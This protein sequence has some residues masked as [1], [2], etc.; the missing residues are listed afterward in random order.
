[1]TK[2]TERNYS[3]DQ[4]MLNVAS[5]LVSDFRRDSNDP[6]FAA[7]FLSKVEIKD[8]IGARESIPATLESDDPWTF[9]AK[10]QI[11]SVFKRYRFQVDTYSD[12]EL[13]DK[14]VKSF[15]ETQDRL[16]HVDLERQSQ[17]VNAVLDRAARYI[18]N[19]L[20]EYDD[21]E[22]RDLCR[23][24]R[25]ASVGIPARKAC[26]A[27]RWEV[28]VSGSHE[29][30]SW[31]D[32]EMSQIE[33]VKTY[34]QTQIDSDPERRSIYQEVDSLTLVLV[35]KTFKSLRSIMPNTTIGSYMSYGLGE[36]MRIRLKRKGYDIRTLQMRHRYLAQLAS[37][38]N[39][40][41]TADLSSASDSISVAL[42]D[43]LF[44]RDWCEILHR[45]RVGR[46]NLPDSTC[47]ES[48]TFC[49]MGV[50][51]TFPLQT[52]VFLALLKAIESCLFDRR[53]RRTI[54]VY[55]DDMIYHKRL[56]KA[57]VHV[58][59]QI[60]FVI[61]L[62]KTYHDSGFRESCG[63]DYFHGV[64]VRPFQPQNGPA[65]VGKKAYEAI[66]YKYINGLLMRWSEYEIVGT[67]RYLTSEL[68]T[69]VGKCKLVPGD[70]P[71]DAGIKCPTLTHW[72]FLSVVKCVKPKHIGH[73][74]YRFPYL[75]FAS[76]I[77]KEVRHEPYVW[78]ALRC[79]RNHSALQLVHFSYR[80]PAECPRRNSIDE[81]TGVDSVHVPLLITKEDRPIKT[82]RSKLTG[83]R[84]RRT[85]TFV[86]I[87][88]R[89]RY[90]RQSGT[91]C[92]EDRR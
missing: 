82:F 37:Q 85:S 47:I 88:Q 3:V 75:R 42:V 33:S 87:G 30:I 84:L 13:L 79:R 8:V 62:D 31:F 59:T 70:F 39:L 1:M 28:P 24:G 61:N 60:G 68:E 25:R 11:Q 54:S 91:S 36:M 23:F 16:A 72:N 21:A 83:R 63:G 38:N 71:D 44:P 45:S 49:T 19:C 26:E 53:D 12:Q 5:T 9:K 81:L 73:G 35:P 69:L 48:L 76:E 34:W 40:Y 51:Y 90:M 32:S 20:G 56:H 22:H 27:A 4:L 66:L 80:E 52:L 10:Y 57:V 89:G 15:H 58:F 6:T 78:A 65:S 14:A 43:R 92:F 18:A 86:S 41:V 46:V 29:Q 50:G 17:F 67:L 7:S 2:K 64:D 55:G 77:V 74:V